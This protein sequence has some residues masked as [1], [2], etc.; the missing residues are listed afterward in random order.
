MPAHVGEMQILETEGKTRLHI[1]ATE[2]RWD[3]AINP[4]HERPP[5]KR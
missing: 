5:A 3:A 2:R 1:Q 4:A